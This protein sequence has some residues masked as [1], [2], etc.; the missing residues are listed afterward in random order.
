MHNNPKLMTAERKRV[1]LYIDESGQDTKGQLFIVAG[2]AVQDS[3]KFRQLCESF[4][5]TSGKRKKKWA[6]AK[7]DKR[8]NY[9]RAVIQE[10]AS[11]NV[12]LFYSVFRKTTDYDTATINGIA[13]S[14]L[15]LSPSN[16]H[17]YVHVD[18]LAKTKRGGYKTGLRRLGFPVKKVI[19]VAKDENEPL[20]RLA[21]AIAGAAGQLL[22]HHSPD[23]ET[24]FSEAKQ[25][26]IL[27]EL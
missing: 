3:D 7:R 17:V 26:G 24:L 21:D 19:R 6:S 12:T 22:K 9:L 2:V 14:I 23:L 13:K 20:I 25:R 27:I 5:K 1:D 15:R 8:L 18:G 16:S 11:L 10:A 4:E